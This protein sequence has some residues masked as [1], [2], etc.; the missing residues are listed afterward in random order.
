MAGIRKIW[1]IGEFSG[2]AVIEEGAGLRPCD[3]KIRIPWSHGEDIFEVI[4]VRARNLGIIQLARQ[5]PSCTSRRCHS[6]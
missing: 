4:P 1:V 3:R 2:L 5:L 6:K